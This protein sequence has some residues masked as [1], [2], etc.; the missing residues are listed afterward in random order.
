MDGRDK[1]VGKKELRMDIKQMKVMKCH[2]KFRQVKNS[3]KWPTVIC[4]K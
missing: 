2:V 3:E 4:S 1:S